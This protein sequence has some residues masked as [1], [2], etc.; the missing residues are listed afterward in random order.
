MKLTWKTCARIVVS[1]FVLYLGIYYWSSVSGML[2][3]MASAAV[4]ILIGLIIAYALNIL[5]SFYE[6][7]YFTKFAQKPV[8]AKTR[9]VVCMLAAI[10]TLIALI[11][12]VI[13]QVI[14]ELIS[15]VGFLISEIPP[16]VDRVLNSELIRDILPEAAITYLDSID[17]K[18][19]ISNIANVVLSGVGSAAT[20]LVTAVSSVI[21]GLI[22]AFL[23]IIFAVYLLT[24]KERLQGQLNRL[25][26]TYLPKS[27]DRIRY[28]ATVFN[29]S[30]R[31]YI[32]GQCT[33]AVIL[34]LLCIGGMLI[35]RFPY[36]G[37]IGTLVGFTAL[38]P[39]AGA[40]IG[41]IVGAVMIFTVSPIKALL[42]IV[43]ILVLQQLEGNLIYP[44]VVGKSIGLPGL[45]VLAA[46]TLGGGILGIFGMLLGVPVAAAF[47]RLLR[48]DVRRRE[49]LEPKAAAEQAVSPESE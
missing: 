48:H 47:Y 21:S 19:V 39:I 34:G 35:F 5:M 42:F 29:E 14:P 33:E 23:S 8:V 41:A 38:I 3:K 24:S 36:A 15:C 16:A 6:K 9:R 2:G 17:W 27:E 13:W 26:H 18:Q 1:V 11:A 4:P 28:V 45:W 32:V 7:H 25:I 30:F 31:G 46:I 20:Y 12:L 40:Y 49:R 37:M 10:I 22:T 43:F 44:K